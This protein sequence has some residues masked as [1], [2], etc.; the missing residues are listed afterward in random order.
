MSRESEM[1]RVAVYMQF[2]RGEVLFN[3][4]YFSDLS[5]QDQIQ[6]ITEEKEYWRKNLQDCDFADKYIK[7]LNELL[8]EIKVRIDT[9]YHNLNKL[10][11]GTYTMS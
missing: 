7:L 2:F 4:L 10:I 1:C 3:D 5:T 9:E 6:K 11:E 8:D